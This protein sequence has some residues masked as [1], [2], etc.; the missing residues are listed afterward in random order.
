MIG[1]PLPPGSISRSRSRRPLQ[2][3]ENCLLLLLLW[4]APWWALSVAVR[5]VW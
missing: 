5:V 3:L 4:L 2:V 1:G